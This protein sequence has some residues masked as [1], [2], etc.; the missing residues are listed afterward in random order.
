MSIDLQKGQRLDVGLSKIHVGLGW[1]PAEG[2]SNFDYDLDASA[3]ML[4]AN[5]KL[6]TDQFFVF[7][8]NKV[9]PDGAVAAGEDDQSG[10]S[11]AG[12]D[13]ETIDI[14]LDRVDQRVQEILICV[15]IHE[16][17]ERRQNFGQV[18]NA[19]IRIV[20]GQDNVE[21]AKYELA[22][23]FSVETAVEFG[24]L[25]RRESKWRFEAVGIGY[26]GGLNELVNRYQ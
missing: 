14:D 23:D 3:F 4:G 20:N 1:D 12:G 2:K 25:Y 8:N 11:T 7:Y 9:S 10:T 24:R 17:Q 22:E 6:V 18:G 26:R 21:L 13:D 16:A 15:S 5:K 19:F